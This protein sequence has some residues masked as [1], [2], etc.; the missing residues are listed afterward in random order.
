[1]FVDPPYLA[2]YHHERVRLTA[3]RWLRPDAALDALAAEAL[4]WLDAQLDALCAALHLFSPGGQSVPPL[5]LAVERS[6][7]VV[8][9]RWAAAWAAPER[10]PIV[11]LLATAEEETARELTLRCTRSDLLNLH[12]EIRSALSVLGR[13]PSPWAEVMRQLEAS[14][15]REHRS[16]AP[17]WPA[18]EPAAAL[19]AAQHLRWILAFGDDATTPSPWGPLLAIFERGAWPM[20]LPDGTALV[21][22]PLVSAG[23]LVAEPEGDPA[24]PPLPVA[25]S[26]RSVLP[27][28]FRALEAAGVCVPPALVHYGFERPL[29]GEPLRVTAEPVDPLSAARGGWTEEGDG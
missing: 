14:A 16:E 13:A 9:D 19:A 23:R 4:A 21:Y 28:A 17:R 18:N 6:V 20:L 11:A 5:T 24:R 15:R 22:V 12:W 25:E 26:R 2:A 27:R 1:M 29:R 7:R 8:G 3:I 10:H